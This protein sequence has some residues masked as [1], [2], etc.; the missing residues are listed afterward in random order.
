[1]IT[2]EDL[3][4]KIEN[5][6]KYLEIIDPITAK[7]K[8]VVYTPEK[9]VDFMIESIDF[10]LMKF[11]NL[12]KGIRTEN[13]LKYLD[14]AAGTNTFACGL[15]K[16]AK[17]RFLDEGPSHPIAQNAFDKWVKNGFLNNFYI[18]EILKESYLLGHIRILSK[19]HE[20]GL[21]LKSN[22]LNLNSSLGN[23]FLNPN[24]LKKKDLNEV[25]VI[26]GNPPYNLSSQNNC[27]WINEKIMDYKN[28]LKERN[29]KIISDDYVK[30][31]RFGQWKIEQAG[32]GILAMI[33]NNRY[34]EGQMFSIMRKSLRKSFDHIYIVNLHGDM[35]KKETGNP[36]DIRIGVCIAFMV[37]IDNSLDKNAAIH[38]MDIPNPTREEKFSILSHGF[39]EERFK[40]LSETK[41]NYFVDIDT[42]LLDRYESFPSIDSFF[43]SSPTSGIMVGKD[44]LLLDTDRKNIETNLKLFFNKDFDRLDE[45]K[46][47]TQDSKSWKKKK[48]YSKTNL[49]QVLSKIT[50]I[51]YRGF[52]FRYIAYDRSIVEGH[53]MGYIDQ[54]SNEN[55]AITI[56]KSSRKA[57]FCTA[58]ISNKLIEK[59]FMSVTDTSYA[60]L[61]E[62]DG[63][64]NINLPKLSYSCHGEDLFYYIYGILFSMTY[65][66]RYDEYLLKGFPRIPITKDQ[67]LFNEMSEIGKILARAHML[68]IDN[69]KK[70]ELSDIS[71]DQWV[72]KDFYYSPEEECI[73]FNKSK[74]IWIKGITLPMWEFSIGNIPQ[75]PQFLKS[76]KF[77]SVRKWNTLQRSLTHEELVIFLKICTAI[78]KTLKTLPNIDEIYKKI[79]ILE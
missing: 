68:D 47:K 23:T 26:M 74:T 60:F 70:F 6:G 4:N 18:N 54:I 11:F 63:K 19:L 2:S 73:H 7:E 72:V 58:F 45:L 69:R 52:D 17:R 79:D 37:R 27:P 50:L 21:K 42:D 1:M 25:F 41:K 28:G 38:Y 43:V 35:R 53:R 44:H 15:L 51:Q 30:F 22:E 64:P 36:F 5:Y 39:N 76:R 33:T 40:L 75:L 14:P 3:L 9:I 49:E 46:I 66:K 31:L 12:K 48:V 59:C 62:K 13:N 32:T 8:G 55:P 65:R 10:L 61:L 67:N 77:S 24:Y 29:K 20:L 78:D 56:S 34:L 16:Y 71:P 57:H